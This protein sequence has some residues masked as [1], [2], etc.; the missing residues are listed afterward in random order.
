MATCMCRYATEAGTA[1]GCTTATRCGIG[2]GIRWSTACRF[3]LN[4]VWSAFSRPRCW[5][6]IFSLNSVEDAVRV[7]EEK[8][9]G[10][11]LEEI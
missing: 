4:L 11:S 9:V 2:L 8:V 7:Q 5:R 3:L 1:W 6:F 10:R